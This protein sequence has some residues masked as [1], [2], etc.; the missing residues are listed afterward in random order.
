MQ[1]ADV[2]DEMEDDAGEDAGEEEDGEYEEE[3]VEIMD[4]G[5]NA[6]GVFAGHTGELFPI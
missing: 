5:D 2:G 4:R 1:C 6:N 3:V